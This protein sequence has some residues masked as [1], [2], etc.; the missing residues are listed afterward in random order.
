MT[1]PVGGTLLGVVP[2]KK[3]EESV[4]APHD[5]SKPPDTPP[6]VELPEGEFY[7]L[8]HPGR[9]TKAPIVGG[10]WSKVRA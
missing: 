10:V 7:G 9:R 4:I 5:C 1:N 3:V 6:A 8:G 2:R